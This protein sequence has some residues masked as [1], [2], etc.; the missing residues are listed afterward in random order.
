MPL[1]NLIQE[2]RLSIKRDERT[3]RTYFAV[4]AGAAG[5]A[6]CVFGALAFACEQAQAS[7]SKLN[8]T[9]QKIA[10]M[11]QMFDSLRSGLLL[12]VL[13]IFLLLAAN[14]QSFKLAFV[15]ISTVPAV[16]AGGVGTILIVIAW[17]YLFPKLRK[18]DA[19]V[20]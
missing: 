1:I 10:P 4:F 20:A 3:A 8:A 12:A 13:V 7:E 6:I 15:V 11:M 5:G 14:F 9:R 2:Q 19:L 18:V 16:I 17:W